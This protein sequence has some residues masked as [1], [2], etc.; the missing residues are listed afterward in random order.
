MLMMK[1]MLT[2]MTFDLPGSS[3]RWCRC[4]II[5][6]LTN[7]RLDMAEIIRAEVKRSIVHKVRGISRGFLVDEKKT[8]ETWLRTE[9]INIEEFARYEQVHFLHLCT[10]QS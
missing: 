1:T 10:S 7:P 4:V 3:P 8:G 2:T 9:G 6:D 5:A